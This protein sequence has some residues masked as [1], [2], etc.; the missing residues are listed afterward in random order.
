MVATDGHIPVLAAEVLEQLQASVGSRRLLDATFGGGGH[1]RA[2]LEAAAG[3]TVHAL[4]A[5]PEAAP[6]AER[7]RTDFSD[8]FTFAPGNFEDLGELTAGEFDAILFDLGLSSFHFDT[9]ER[10]FAFRHD[11]PLD[12]RLDPREG[13]SAHTFLERADHF[14][15]VRAIRDYGE[16]PR[17]RRI[18]DVIE[19]ARGTDALRRT[20]AFAELIENALGPAARRKSKIHP[21]TRTFQGVRIAVNRELEVIERALPQAFSRLR[22]G[23]RL[24]VISFHSLEDRIAKRYFRHLAGRPES[25]RD[26]RP[27][28]ERPVYGRELTRRPLVPGEAECTANPR[29]RS[30]KLRVIEKTAPF[31]VS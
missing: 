22:V 19:R 24:A 31:S 13:C 15:L 2:W 16:E 30:A 20:V 5:D 9:P 11:G 26:N 14:E 27:A 12:M 7:L 4:D 10:G 6:R 18:V 3:N 25:S 8:R 29:A 17:W 23:G 21:A 28:D 1:S